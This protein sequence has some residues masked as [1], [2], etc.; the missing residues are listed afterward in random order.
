[1]I[2]ATTPNPSDRFAVL[3]ESLSAIRPRNAPQKGDS[4]CKFASIARLVFDAIRLVA[5]ASAPLTFAVARE[6]QEHETIN[7]AV[8]K[9]DETVGKITL[10]HGQFESLGMHQ[11]MATVINT[12]Q[13]E[14]TH[15]SRSPKT[16]GRSKPC[17]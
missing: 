15:R 8:Q 12:G 10:T 9:I 3:E 1:M 4:M 7:G 14:Q 11:R 6:G 16:I 17:R 13:S 2:M 5:F